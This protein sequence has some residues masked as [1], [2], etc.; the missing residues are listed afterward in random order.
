MIRQLTPVGDGFGLVLDRS[1][2]NRL[3]IDG[4]T[5]LEVT[6]EDSGIFIRPIM[7]E[8]QEQFVESAKRMMEIHQ[9]V[10]RKLAEDR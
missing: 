6:I 5:Q 7:H 8:I 10:F 9:D 2:L 3:G 4:N 1:I